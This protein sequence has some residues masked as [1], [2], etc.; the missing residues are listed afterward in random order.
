MIWNSDSIY[1]LR[2][3]IERDI[4][5]RQIIREISIDT[6]LE[7]TDEP[8]FPFT[9]KEDRINMN[10]RMPYILYSYNEEEMRDIIYYRSNPNSFLNLID[11][12]SVSTMPIS[13]RKDCI[14]AFSNHKFNLVKSEPMCGNTTLIGFMIYHYICFNV[15]KSALYVANDYNIACLIQIIMDFYH[16]TPFYLKPG[17]IKRTN[18]E[19]VF[20]NGSR[21]RANTNNKL[22]ISSNYN[23]IMT[24]NVEVTSSILLCLVPVMTALRDSRFIALIYNEVNRVYPIIFNKLDIISY[25]RQSNLDKLV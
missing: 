19:I 15:D 14:E 6:I 13:F 4:S 11:N 3:Q 5:V 24:D 21:I 2:K 12:Q 7:D 22:T 9:T 17:V 1:R 10:E 18:S 8:S 25:R 23:I 20:D 16:R